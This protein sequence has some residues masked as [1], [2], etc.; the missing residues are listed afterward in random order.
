MS[1]SRNK[2]KNNPMYGMRREKCPSWKGGRVERAGGPVR[3]FIPEHK[4]ADIKGYVYEHRL[5][6]EEKIKRFLK[7]WE[8]VHHI[9]KDC[10]KIN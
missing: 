7:P 10:S 8:I 1:K 9:D 4:Y 2:G 6:M 3:I 5:V